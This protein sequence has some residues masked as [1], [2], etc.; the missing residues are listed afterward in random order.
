[1]IDPVSAQ[2]LVPGGANTRAQR[3]KAKLRE[4]CKQFESIFL[5][6]MLKEARADEA[7]W[8]DGEKSPFGA[9]EET[10][11]EMTAETLSE[12]GGIGLWE[13]LYESLEDNAG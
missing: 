13:M 11:M 6:K 9:L 4:A 10:A 3:E 2:E 7:F 1:M 12:Q 8:E 5:A